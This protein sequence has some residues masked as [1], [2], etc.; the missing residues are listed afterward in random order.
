MEGRDDFAD[1]PPEVWR[2]LDFTQ[3]HAA[4]LF[5]DLENSVMLSSTL[6]PHEYQR[7]INDFQTA[8]LNL[9]WELEEK[10]QHV[11]EY[12]VAGD[13]F[14][15]FFYDPA[16][17]RRNYK[18]DGLEPAKDQKRDDLIAES[19][20]I[21]REIVFGGLRAAIQL[22]NMWLAHNL[23]LKRVRNKQ[24]PLGLGIGLHAGRVHLCE[25]PDGKR[26]IE[27]YAVNMG[28]RI[29]TCARH[30]KYS[31][32][33][34]SQEAHDILRSSVL[35]H[36]L[37]RQRVFFHKH[38]LGEELLKGIIRSQPVYE[39]K[40]YSRIGIKS[41]KDVIRQYEA[42]FTHDPTNIWAYYQLFEHYA[43][44]KKD[45][46][47][48]LPLAKRAHT[49]YPEDE[50][51][52]LDLSRYY[53][54]Q[55]CFDQAQRYAERALELN[56]S[57]DL[58]YEQLAWLAQVR[59]ET[60]VQREYLSKAASLAPGSPVNH[61]NLG[62]VLCQAGEPTEGA[63]HLLEALKGYPEYPKYPGCLDTLAGLKKDGILP[64]PVEEYLNSQGYEL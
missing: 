55:E 32:I 52:L 3:V 48:I 54:Q 42:L 50:K 9:V 10:S 1:L 63:Y 45:W 46:E 40:F 26:R 18:L 51:V 7:L 31:R 20:R 36:T 16:E 61:L 21:N 53:Y 8:M 49:V 24:E 38:E 12:H 60:V 39:L 23:N 30:G 44:E 64:E 57:F 11:G 5:A 29:E 43:Y 34:L 13:Q 59:D 35:K 6:R 22:K 19:S 37:L 56:T 58:A 17:V 27:G 4:I 28:K 33:M 47:R 41:P 2:G 62:L 14:S 25:R 15:I